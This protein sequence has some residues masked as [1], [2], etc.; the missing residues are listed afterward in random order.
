MKRNAR[1]TKEVFM[2]SHKNNV[3]LL[4]LATPQFF[5]AILFRAVRGAILVVLNKINQAV[6]FYTSKT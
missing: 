4:W 2:S 1:T 3:I 5:Y 6:F